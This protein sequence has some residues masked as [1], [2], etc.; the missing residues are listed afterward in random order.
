VLLVIANF[1]AS[2]FCAVLSSSMGAEL[3][4]RE[5]I[6]LPRSQGMRVVGVLLSH[7]L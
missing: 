5:F 4:M 6:L 1:L 3:E 7:C 2:R